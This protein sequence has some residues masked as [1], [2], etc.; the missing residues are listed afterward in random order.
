MWRRWEVAGGGASVD[1]VCELGRRGVSSREREREREVGADARC[2]LVKLL[3]FHHPPL[4]PTE[5]I[6][7]PSAAPKVDGNYFFFCRLTRV[8]GNCCSFIGF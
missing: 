4:K 7:F 5:V 3:F 2:F 1:L 8:N 6:F